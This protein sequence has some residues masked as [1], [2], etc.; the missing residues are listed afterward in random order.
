MLNVTE[1]CL[2]LKEH[3]NGSIKIIFWVQLKFCAYYT[4]LLET[5]F[6]PGFYD[7]LHKIHLL[8]VLKHLLIVLIAFETFTVVQMI[9]VMMNNSSLLLN[10]LHPKSSKYFYSWFMDRENALQRG[11]IICSKFMNQSYGQDHIPFVTTI[12]Q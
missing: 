3:W 1:N 12:E 7:K 4:F 8:N 10:A 9:V 6:T 5:F 2:F 11:R